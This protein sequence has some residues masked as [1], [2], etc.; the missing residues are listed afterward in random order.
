M[1]LFIVKLFQAI[2]L[3]NVLFNQANIVQTLKEFLKR[4]KKLTSDLSMVPFNI[5]WGTCV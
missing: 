4:F 1:K 3:K 5:P 2:F